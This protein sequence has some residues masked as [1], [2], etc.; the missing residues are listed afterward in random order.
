MPRNHLQLQESMPSE[1]KEKKKGREREKGGLSL[2]AL[3]FSHLSLLQGNCVPSIRLRVRLLA[4]LIR[5]SCHLN[6]E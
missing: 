1:W 5:L 2:S 3:P 4:P 6:N